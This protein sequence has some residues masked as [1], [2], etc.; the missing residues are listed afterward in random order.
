MLFMVKYDLWLLYIYGK[1]AHALDLLTCDTVYLGLFLL[2]A[3]F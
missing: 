1:H 2:L 3:K